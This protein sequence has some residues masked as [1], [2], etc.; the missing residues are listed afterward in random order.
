MA[1]I[2][3]YPDKPKPYRVMYRDPEGKQHG[4]SFRRK[5]DADRFVTEIEHSKLSGTYVNRNKSE[6]P[7]AAMA[8]LWKQSIANVKPDIEK[9]YIRICN[10]RLIPYFGA[11]PIG[12]IDTLAVK[13]FLKKIDAKPGTTRNAKAVLSLVMNAAVEGGYIPT[14]P[15][16]GIKVR[17]G[18]PEQMLFLTHDEVRTLARVIHPR[19]RLP[20]LI[21]A[22]CGPRAEELWSLRAGHF[23]EETGDLRIETVNESDEVELDE[24]DMPKTG[25]FRHIQ[26]PR[27]LIPEVK[28]WIKENDL[29]HDDLLFR[30]REG[31]RVNHNN[32]YR[33]HYN[34][35]LIKASLNPKV[36]FHDLR[37]TC[38][39]FYF[40]RGASGEEVRQ[41]LGHSSI[42][43][44]Y[45]YAHVFPDAFKQRVLS[46]DVD[47]ATAIAN[48][49]LVT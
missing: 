14:N 46:I 17:R 33:R 16:T 39:A 21:A 26:M 40:A 10:A 4:R 36:R 42:Q 27:I 38:A 29:K 45:K 31:F 24:D 37:H 47:I 6:L 7:F 25:V 35:A 43:M 28:S 22:Y 32:F 41:V 5:I 44:T 34:P 13:T 3:R 23:N 20:I 1:S 19:F 9:E 49:P 48:E 30:T 18:R 11:T 15:C 8:D 12:R 2:H